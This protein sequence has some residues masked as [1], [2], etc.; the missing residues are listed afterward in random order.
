MR[1]ILMCKMISRSHGGV[2]VPDFI[3]PGVVAP[4]PVPVPVDRRPI[5][6]L[7]HQTASL[8]LLWKPTSRCVSTSKTIFLHIGIDFELRQTR[9]E[10]LEKTKTKTQTKQA[11]ARYVSRYVCVLLRT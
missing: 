10:G 7:L 4:G 3:H 2:F 11:M 6:S 8:A 5:F 1:R 9:A